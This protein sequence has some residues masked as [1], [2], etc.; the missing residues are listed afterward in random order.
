MATAVARLH[1][2]RPEIRINLIEGYSETMIERLQ[3]GEFDLIAGDTGGQQLPSDLTQELLYSGNDI[4]AARAEHPLARR[5]NL[6]LKALQD[7]TWMVP[8][9][10]TSD[11]SIIIDAFV[12]EGLEPPKKIIGT[13]AYMVGMH[14]ILRND[15]L[16]MTPPGLIGQPFDN[17]HQLFRALDIDKPTVQRN[18]CL[19][20]RTDQPLSPAA[21]VLFSEVQDACQD[22]LQQTRQVVVK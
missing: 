4:I 12:Q 18:A 17:K 11:F 13:D 5:K 19:I 21:S 22:L 10:R 7:Y 2:V 1:E 16:I 14:L 3:E 15:F 20:R 8:Y 6:K 9:T